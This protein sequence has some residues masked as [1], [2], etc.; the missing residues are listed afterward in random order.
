MRKLT[1]T[2]LAL[3]VAVGAGELSAQGG[4]S[5]DGSATVTIPEVLRISVGDLVIPETA[6]DF[7]SG[8]QSEG[9]GQVTVTTRS[10]VEHGV[11][12]TGGDLTMDAYSLPLEVREAGGDFE[13]V[14]ASAVRALANL[15]R[16]SQSNS[17]DFRVTADLEQHA[18]GTYEGTITYTVVADE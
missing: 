17:V 11:D 14:S 3:L 13:P 6:F 16:G 15:A 2:M 12:V 7:E 1:G 10:N 9:E 5:A 4:P 18:P 8:S